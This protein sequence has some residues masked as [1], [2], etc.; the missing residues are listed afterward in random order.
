MADE[1]LPM[2][3]VRPRKRRRLP[4]RCPNH[5]PGVRV[6]AS[7]RVGARDHSY[8][9][10]CAVFLTAPCATTDDTRRPS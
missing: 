10:P 9:L 8:C 1:T 4:P 2:P 7:V 3:E 5:P 6:V